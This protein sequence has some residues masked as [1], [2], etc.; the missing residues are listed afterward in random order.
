MGAPHLVARTDSNGE[1]GHGEEVQGARR[2]GGVRRVG[3]ELA[4]GGAVRV[5]ALG[6]VLVDGVLVDPASEKAELVLR[7]VQAAPVGVGRRLKGDQELV[8]HGS[9]DAAAIGDADRRRP[10]ANAGDQEREEHQDTYNLR[11]PR[12]LGGG[13]ETRREMVVTNVASSVLACGSEE[14]VE[15]RGGGRVCG[16]VALRARECTSLVLCTAMADTCV[17]ISMQKVVSKKLLKLV[18]TTDGSKWLTRAQS[19]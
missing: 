14:C 8:I 18:N 5:G 17:R 7:G 16:G 6:D 9:V 10:S 3:L 4:A 2:V 1:L 13:G 11:D 19:R 12:W 15:R